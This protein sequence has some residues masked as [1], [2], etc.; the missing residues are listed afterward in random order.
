MEYIYPAFNRECMPFEIRAVQQ[1]QVLTLSNA[2]VL[3]L[4]KD[5]TD[6]VDKKEPERYLRFEFTINAH[7][8]EIKVVCYPNDKLMEEIEALCKSFGG[9]IPNRFLCAIALHVPWLCSYGERIVK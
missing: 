9:D 7:L 2:S 5:S 6:I 8:C 1:A 3:K 4:I